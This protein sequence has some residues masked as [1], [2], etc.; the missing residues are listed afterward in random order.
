MSTCVGMDMGMGTYT[1]MAMEWE[2]GMDTGMSHV[3]HGTYAPCATANALRAAAQVRA[4]DE[5]MV[6]A[7]HVLTSLMHVADVLAVCTPGTAS[8]GQRTCHR[9]T[10]DSRMYKLTHEQTHAWSGDPP[11]APNPTGGPATSHV[12][13][14]RPPLSVARRLR[15]RSTNLRP[16]TLPVRKLLGLA[17]C[18][19]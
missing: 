8:S 10:Q 6:E 5:N 9:Y 16:P 19:L 17:F 11:Q 12:L 14:V 18:H 3:P 7:G 15:L 4:V 2:M 1:G 13:Q